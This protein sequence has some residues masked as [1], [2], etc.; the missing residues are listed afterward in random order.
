MPDKIFGDLLYNDD[1]TGVMDKL[2]ITGEFDKDAISKINVALVAFS[3]RAYQGK[4]IHPQ[5]IAEFGMLCY[6]IPQFE[7]IEGVD[8]LEDIV[9]DLLETLSTM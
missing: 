7:S 9:L 1:T 5:D 2:H 4:P 8:E 6:D 3:K